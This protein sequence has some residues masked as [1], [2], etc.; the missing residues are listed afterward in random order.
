MDE[1]NVQSATEWCDKLEF[2]R[3]HGYLILLV[4]LVLIFD[5]YDSQIIAY[6]MPQI[7]KEWGLSPI[8]LGSI[9]SYGFV[10]LMIGAAGFGVI[11]DYVGRKKSLMTAMVIFSIFS[12]AAYFAPNFGVFCTLRLLAGLGLGAALPLA[13]TITSEFAPAKLRARVVTGMFAGFTLGWALA[14]IVAMI[15][16]PVFGWR[17]CL[18]L[19]ALPILFVPVL[20]LCLPESIRFL[21]G[22]KRYGEAAKELKRIEKVA[23]LSPRQWTEQSFL[24]PAGREDCRDARQGGP[25]IRD[26]FS[27]N[28]AIMTILIWLTYFFSLLVIYGLAT[29]LPTLLVKQGFSAV[30]SYSFGLVQAVGCAIGGFVLGGLMDRFGRKRVLI[31]SYIAG[32]ISV[33]L[34]GFVTNIALLYAAGLATGL[35]VL[36][37]N[38]AVH[39]VTGE[40][41]PTKVRATGMGWGLTFGRFGSIVGPILGGAFQMA[42]LSFGQY[43]MAFAVPCFLIAAII[44]YYRV[45]VTSEGLEEVV[46]KL[47]T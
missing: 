3:F 41:Y 40:I 28:L 24:G 46:V 12:G 39:V 13:I 45:N 38:N 44:S 30:K 42:G 16:T 31:A 4:G 34:F 27:G 8:R 35:F 5:G 14:A 33:W 19:G 37:T 21:A 29:W 18:L 9:A 47:A 43:F 7:M 36:G 22:K 6:A 20:G 23:R 1:R 26:L 2:N 11:A 17:M 25:G 15:V 32:G 10:G